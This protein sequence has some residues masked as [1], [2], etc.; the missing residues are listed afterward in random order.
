ML[1]FITLTVSLLPHEPIPHFI[2]IQ[3]CLSK[4]IGKKEENQKKKTWRE[5]TNGGVQMKM[6]IIKQQN[7]NECVSNRKIIKIESLSCLQDIKSPS[8]CLITYSPNKFY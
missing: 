5:N 2:Y 8:R 7:P 3:V 1:I 4:R 6:L